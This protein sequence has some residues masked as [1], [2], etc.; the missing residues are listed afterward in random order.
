MNILDT[1]DLQNRLDK[2]K[3]ELEA[4]TQR[5]EDVKWQ[6][7]E[8]ELDLGLELELE[9]E[10]DEAKHQLQMWKDNNGKELNDLQELAEYLEYYGWI[11]GLQ[12]IDR[13]DFKE[14]AQEYAQ[15]YVEFT[16]RWPFNHIDWQRAFRDLRQYFEEVDFL[17]YRL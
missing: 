6:L 7:V 9:L 1:R 13:R 15:E 2:L 8:L 10:I 4:L 17:F 11:D 12:L 3:N 5:L 16:E 14:Y